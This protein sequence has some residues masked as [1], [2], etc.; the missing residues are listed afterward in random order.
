VGSRGGSSGETSTG[1]N[2]GQGGGAV[3]PKPHGAGGNKIGKTSPVTRPHLRN[4]GARN[5]KVRGG[6]P[7]RTGLNERNKRPARVVEKRSYCWVCAPGQL[8]VRVGLDQGDHDT[9][10]TRHTRT[11]QNNAGNGRAEIGPAVKRG[12]HS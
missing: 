5:Q 10:K 9:I 4:T 6:R 8:C 12:A 7:T 2:P 3:L 1:A 11:R